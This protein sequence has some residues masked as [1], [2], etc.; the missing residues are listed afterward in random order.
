MTE[1][2]AVQIPENWQ[3]KSIEQYL[4][5]EMLLTA[6]Q[7]R[8]LKFCE[9]GIRR[10][11]KKCRVNQQLQTNDI[12]EIQLREKRD[13]YG[14][15]EASGVMPEILYEDRDVICVWKPAGRVTHPVA[16]HRK[17]TVA[18]DLVT[19]FASREEETMIHSIGRLDKDTAGILVFAK[20][21]I[22][23]AR[24]WKQKEEGTFTKEYLA[25]CQG[26]FPEAARSRE[27]RLDAPIGK[28]EAVPGQGQ[29]MQ[30]DKKG[31]RAV[32]RYL[33]LEQQPERALIRLRLENG[34]THQIR[35]HMAYIGHPLE[36]D[37]LY[38]T[39]IPHRDAARLCAWK[40][41]FLQPFTKKEILLEHQTPLWSISSCKVPK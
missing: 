25:W 40:V 2:I 22:A 11:G 1:T 37:S 9:D 8:S 12:L 36:G 39:G 7:I 21:R 34:R 23:A 32:T 4:K 41:R 16:G 29:K 14:K 6:A 18:G 15:V 31:K 3:G 30:V 38:G 10:N 5:K 26:V 33:V 27:Q 17:D 19:Y 20:N 24:L 13:G 28:A 35:V